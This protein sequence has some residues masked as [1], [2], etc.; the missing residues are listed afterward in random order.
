M[1]HNEFKFCFGKTY[2]TKHDNYN[3]YYELLLN[4]IQ[5]NPFTI[6]NLQN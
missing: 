4:L 5:F 1:L 2:L 6:K 3:Y